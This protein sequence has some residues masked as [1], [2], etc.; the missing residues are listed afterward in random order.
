MASDFSTRDSNCDPLYSFFLIHS[1]LL[2]DIA[3]SFDIILSNSINQVSTH[4]SDN[5]NDTNS[6]ID[7]MFL[8]PN[9]LEINNHTIC[10]ELCYPSDYALLIVNISITEEFIQDK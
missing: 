5:I 2:F 10:P 3:D 7:L 8:R 1:N 4:Y 9:S 6:V